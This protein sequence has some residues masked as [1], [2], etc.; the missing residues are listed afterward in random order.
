MASLLIAAGGSLT[1]ATQA[2][3]ENLG[4]AAFLIRLRAAE[5]LA[6]VDGASFQDVI[7]L[8]GKTNVRLTLTRVGA[9]LYMQVR[10]TIFGSPAIIDFFAER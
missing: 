2:K 5:L 7:A 10:D 1:A 4:T 3:Y 9:S 6:I 8:P